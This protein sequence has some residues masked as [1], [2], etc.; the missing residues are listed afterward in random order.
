MEGMENKNKKLIIDFIV[1][2]AIFIINIG[3]LTVL[4]FGIAVSIDLVESIIRE[5]FK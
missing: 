5:V 2:S 1:K 3:I 4:I